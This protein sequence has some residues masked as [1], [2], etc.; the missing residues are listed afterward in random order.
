MD[1]LSVPVYEADADE[2]G[3]LLGEQAEGPGTVE[4]VLGALVGQEATLDEVVAEQGLEAGRVRLVVRVRRLEQPVDRG[5]DRS[6][7]PLVEEPGLYDREQPEYAS[8]AK[9]AASTVET[10]R[11]T[12]AFCPTVIAVLT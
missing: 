5:V 8:A 11:L 1:A 9:P 4:R 3:R 7:D 6:P 2:A 10:S 12:E